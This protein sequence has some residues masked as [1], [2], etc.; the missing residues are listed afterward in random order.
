MSATSR[1]Y[2]KNVEYR[3]EGGTPDAVGAVRLALAFKLKAAV[4]HEMIISLEEE[5]SRRVFIFSIVNEFFD[6]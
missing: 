4:G 2:L 5:I 6:A 3:E 1:S